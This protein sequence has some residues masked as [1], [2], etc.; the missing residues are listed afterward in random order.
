M[1]REDFLY[2]KTAGGTGGGAARNLALRECRG[3]YVAFLDD[4]DRY[5]SG[6]TGAPD[7]FYA[8]I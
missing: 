8:E 1:K 2:V 4:D 6:E 5:P 7:P 3:E